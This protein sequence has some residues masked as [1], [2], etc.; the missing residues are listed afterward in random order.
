MEE[1]EVKGEWKKERSKMNG[2]KIGQRLIE[3]RGE[4][5][6]EERSKVD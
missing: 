3:K 5:W 6:I 1:S 4:W 2:R